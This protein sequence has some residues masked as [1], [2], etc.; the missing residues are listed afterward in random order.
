MA[1]NISVTSV[2]LVITGLVAKLLLKLSVG[3]FFKPTKQGAKTAFVWM[4]ASFVINMIFSLMTAYLTSFLG[5]K[6]INVPTSDLSLSSPSTASVVMQFTYV[7]ILGPI[8]EETIYRGLIIGTL[9]KYGSG[10]AVLMSALAFGLMHGNIPQAVSAFATGVV[11][12]VIAV[13]CG[14]V[15]PTIIIH[16]L[17]NLVANMPDLATAFNIPY[18]DTFYSM[19][20]IAIAL[21]GF[22]VLFT[23]HDFLRYKKDGYILDKKTVSRTIF[24]NPAIFLYLLILIYDMVRQIVYAN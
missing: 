24:T 14:S 13:N 22:F 23:K 7:I 10:P 12:G 16:S 6:G 20:E 21:A 2:S 18:F 17:N 5:A 4:P 3:E 15:V 8:F 1:L 9:S 11:Y 19:L